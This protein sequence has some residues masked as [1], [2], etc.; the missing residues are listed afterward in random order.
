MRV[1]KRFRCPDCGAET[2]HLHLGQSRVLTDRYQCEQC[3]DRHTGPKLTVQDVEEII[4]A[5]GGERL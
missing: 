4:A 3:G 1:R 5:D 2:R